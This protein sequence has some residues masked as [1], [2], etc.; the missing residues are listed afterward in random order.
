V[1]IVLS[2]GV[3]FRGNH[4]HDNVGPGLWCDINCRDVVYEDNLVERNHDSGIFH[5]I[6]Y[7]AVIRITCST[8]TSIVFRERAVARFVWGHATFD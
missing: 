1:K 6:S 4:V 5:E 3:I 7:N 8:A 2:D